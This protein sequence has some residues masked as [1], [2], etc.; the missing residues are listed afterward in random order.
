MNNIIYIVAII[1]AVYVIYD[2][3]TVQKSM[4]PIKKLI[5]TI[6]ALFFSII[7]AIVYYFTVKK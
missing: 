3:F 6:S 4:E 1:C 5:W 2:V 7:T